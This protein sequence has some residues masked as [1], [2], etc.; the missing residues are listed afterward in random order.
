ME[1]ERFSIWLSMAARDRPLRSRIRPELGRA[2]FLRKVGSRFGFT[3]ERIG[4]G[5][6]VGR[7][8]AVNRANTAHPRKVAADTRVV[9]LRRNGQSFAVKDHLRYL[10]RAREAVDR[11]LTLYGP[12]LEPPSSTAFV[13]SCRND[14]HQFRTVLQAQDACEYEDLRPLA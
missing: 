4:R 3:G 14:R 9:R 6:G 8:L 5:A 11:R 2:G 10:V 7:V 12:Q 1:D 13:G